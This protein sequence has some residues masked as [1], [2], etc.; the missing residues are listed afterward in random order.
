MRH[1]VV[2]IKQQGHVSEIDMIKFAEYFGT[3]EGPHPIYNNPDP[4]SPIAVVA[5][6]A[7]NLPDGAE[8]HTDCSWSPTPPLFSVLM[9]KLLPKCGGD[10]L[11]LSSAAAFASL[12][13]GMQSDLRKLSA[14]HDMGSFRNTFAKRG[15]AAGITAGFLHNLYNII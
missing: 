10:T 1:G 7:E 2:F 12:P 5:H 4:T 15:G 11:W 14:V 9:P 3:L 6:D 13:A 8:W